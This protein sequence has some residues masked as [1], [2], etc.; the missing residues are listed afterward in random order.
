MTTKKLVT[1]ALLLAIQVVI[2]A[3]YIPISDT[4]R[5]TFSFVVMMIVGMMADIKTAILY[6]LLEDIIAFITFPSGPFFIGYTLGTMVAMGIYSFFLY[7]EV[8]IKRIILAKT[9]VTIIHNIILNS[10]WNAVLYSNDFIYYFALSVPKNLFL[11][12]FEIAICIILYR[13]IGPLMEKQ[14]RK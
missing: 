1:L 7:K 5:I 12:P 14:G 4:L 3:F 2:S 9:A 10:L 11:L 13:T 8:T 6:G